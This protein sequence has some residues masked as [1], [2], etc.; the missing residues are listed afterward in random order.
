MS[1]FLC[2]K[3]ETRIIPI[4]WIIN[5]FRQLDINKLFVASTTPKMSFSPVLWY[6]CDSKNVI[7]SGRLVINPN[8]IP[9]MDCGTP[10]NK[11][12]PSIEF[13]SLSVIKNNARW[14][15]YAYL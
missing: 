15:E 6:F 2:Y 12:S 1:T 11:H 8:T 13:P 5:K 14:S 3:F 7:N 4:A 10:N 9:T